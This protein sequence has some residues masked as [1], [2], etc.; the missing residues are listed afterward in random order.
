M[1]HARISNEEIDGLRQVTA[2]DPLGNATFRLPGLADLGIECVVDT[3]FVGYWTRSFPPASNANFA[4]M[5]RIIHHLAPN[6]IAGFVLSNGSLSS[7]TSGKDGIPLSDAD[8]I[9]EAA[10]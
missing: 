2:H 10:T 5:Q 6:G 8:D 1:P 3:G 7:N 9:A 4:W